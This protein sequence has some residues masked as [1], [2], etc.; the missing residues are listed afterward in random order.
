MKLNILEKKKI[1]FIIYRFT[2]NNID[3]KRYHYTFA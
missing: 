1:F 3:K 2:E